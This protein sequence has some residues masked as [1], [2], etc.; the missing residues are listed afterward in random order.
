[1]E[2]SETPLTNLEPP[3]SKEQGIY[4]PTLK[5]GKRKKKDAVY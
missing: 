4:T 5:E 1:M 2:L 3:I